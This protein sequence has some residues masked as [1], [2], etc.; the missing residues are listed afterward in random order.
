M[1]FDLVDEGE[2]KGTQDRPLLSGVTAAG[3]GTSAII[4]VAPRQT[5]QAGI[6]A[7]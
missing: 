1:T 5:L 2:E 7:L 6:H 4:S 3:Q